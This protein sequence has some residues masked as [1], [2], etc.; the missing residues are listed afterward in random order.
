MCPYRLEKLQTLA[1]KILAECDHHDSTLNQLEEHV[2][3][4]ESS[5]TSLPPE[6]AAQ[7]MEEL[8]KV[9]TCTQELGKWHS[10]HSKNTVSLHS[11]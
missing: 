11:R 9:A 3:Q 6:E 10:V 5:C 7:L 1:D 2:G 8:K 4:F